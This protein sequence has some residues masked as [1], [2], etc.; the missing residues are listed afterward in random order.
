MWVWVSYQ[1]G[2]YAPDRW[3]APNL[4]TSPS[5]SPNPNPTPNPTPNQ[6]GGARRDGLH[7]VRHRAAP[8]PNPNP[9]LN[10]NPTP[11]PNQVSEE[12]VALLLGLLARKPTQACE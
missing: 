12:L 2:Y 10:P 8:N 5:P 11:T 3:A 4:S 6:V 9:N 1:F 7:L